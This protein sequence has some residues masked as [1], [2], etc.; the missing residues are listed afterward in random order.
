MRTNLAGAVGRRRRAA[1]LKLVVV[2]AAL[3][4]VGLLS[5][6]PAMADDYVSITGSGSSWAANALS[7]WIANIRQQ[8][9][10]INY[11]DNGSSAGRQN[12][13]DNT[14]DFAVSEIPYKF[15]DPNEVTP[16]AG[17]YAY[18]P[19]VAGGTAFMYHLE[20][21][22]QLF[23]NLKLTQAAVADIFTNNVHYWDDPEIV[24]SNPGVALPH[25]SI[26][27][28]ARS[29]GSGTTAEITSWLNQQFSSKWNAYCGSLKRSSCGVTSFFP[30]PDNSSFVAQSSST[31]SAEYIKENDGTIGYDEYSYAKLSGYP[32]AKI[33]NAAGYFALPTAQ[34]DAVALTAAKI[35]TNQNDPAHYLTQDLSDV[36]TNP[37]PRT[38]PLSSYSYF[39]VPTQVAGK[40][41]NDKGKT[42]GA[43]AYYFLCE[44]Q[45]DADKLGYSPL[46]VNLVQAA[47]EQ[48]SK[49]PGVD[50]QS[51]DI[52]NCG[53]PTFDGKH[54]DVNLLAQ[55]APQPDACDKQG[56]DCGGAGGV[57]QP[58]TTDPN[59]APG[60]VTPADSGSGG[61]GAAPAGGTTAPAAAG[62]AA[63][64]GGTAAGGAAAGAGGAAAGGTVAGAKPGTTGAAG[65]TTTVVDPNTGEVKTVP[66]GGGSGSGGGGAAAGSPTKTVVDPETGE[67]K[68]VPVSA[69][70]GSSATGGG[71][72]GTAGASAA[73]GAVAG[74]SGTVAGGGTVLA[75]AVPVS[76]STSL[77]G[78]VGTNALIAL[79]A[80]T[81][82]LTVAAPPLVARLVSKRRSS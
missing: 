22:G 48:V 11:N 29:D 26:I 25:S 55:N 38:Y 63:P 39:I 72:V 13:H 73:A 44:G 19:I 77:S 61:G 34:N 14:V 15:D 64:G 78:G 49:I 45:Q 53:N 75:G 3:L 50:E 51:I 36:Y 58:A 28:I 70:T 24:A 32:V 42:L 5:A 81:L 31:G 54:L 71:T 66:T 59:G 21:G 80:L 43:F 6:G 69:A 41:N 4:P 62:G 68:T 8:G 9:I 2:L 52:A 74:A 82:V 60:G 1:V 46:P 10:S 23:T 47:L 37:D 65:G 18:M 76:T 12:F 35:N 7:D 56:A 40:F 17:S 79:L 27:P 33:L 20:I 30:Y 57:Q 16:P 67:V